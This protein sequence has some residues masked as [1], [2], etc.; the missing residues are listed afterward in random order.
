MDAPRL[1]TARLLLRLPQ[2]GDL[3]QLVTL[4]GAREVAATT[5]RIPHPYTRADGE[6]FIA[7][8]QQELQR[9]TAVMLVMTENGE[10]RGGIGLH[11]GPAHQHA[12]LGFWVG[13]PCW[14]KGHCT[15]AARAVLEHGF[16]ALKLRRIFARHMKENAA[17]GRVLQKLGMRCEGCLREHVLK[18]GVF[19]VVLLYGILAEEFARW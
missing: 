12:E 6:Q 15:E 3:D 14:A 1:H 10:L 7:T 4:A 19:H 2:P 11:L 13:V 9:G 18:W 5:L 17:S 16:G 8:A